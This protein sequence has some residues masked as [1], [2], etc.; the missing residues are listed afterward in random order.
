MVFFPPQNRILLWKYW[1]N[2]FSILVLVFQLD[3]ILG[4]HFVD[5]QIYLY[6]CQQNLSYLILDGLIAEIN[7]D[8]RSN[9]SLAI[10]TEKSNIKREHSIEKPNPAIGGGLAASKLYEAAK[11]A[12]QQCS[13]V[14]INGLV[15]Q[16]VARAS[17]DL[18]KITES[19]GSI[20]SDTII[21]Y[22]GYATLSKGGR[23]L[24]L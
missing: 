8:F 11:A 18:K 15:R 17:E 19:R 6:P 12:K 14:K 7:R 9:L 4:G 3:S 1:K 21:I 5:L 23:S 16:E 2:D 10:T 13:L 22:T 20:N 24:V